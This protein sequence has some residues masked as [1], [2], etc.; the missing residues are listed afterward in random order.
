MTGATVA[1]RLASRLGASFTPFLDATRRGPVEVG[2]SADPSSVSRRRLTLLLISTGHAAIHAQS[3]LLPLVYAIV[4][5]EYGLNERDIGT[6]IAITTAVGGT[7]QLAYGFLTR[8][9]ARPALLA[10][11]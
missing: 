11:G 3:A 6:F 7:M 1:M 10:G 5:V 4:I 9:I 8:F 2:I